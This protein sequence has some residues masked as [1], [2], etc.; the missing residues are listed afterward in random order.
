MKFILCVFIFLTL[1]SNGFSKEI[2]AYFYHN[3]PP[4]AFKKGDPQVGLSEELV[5]LI[6]SK[7]TLK[8][9]K[10]LRPRARLNKEL[11][12]WI[13]LK[14]NLAIPCDSD[15]IVMWVTPKWGWGEK[16]ESRYLW[17]NLFK[18]ED[19]IISNENRKIET[20]NEKE[21]GGMVYAGILGHKAESSIE[22]LL[23]AE[24]I[25][26]EDGT[27]DLAL[28]RRISDGRAGF[29]VLQKSTIDNIFNREE[30]KI[31][32]NKVYI[33]KEPLNSFVLQVMIPLH[34]TDIYQE[35]QKVVN[36]VEFT[37]LLKSYG[38]KK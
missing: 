8:L 3:Q 14:C 32:K 17:I 7:T 38:I 34:R 26:R 35:I 36:S 21:V 23:K 20:I 25:K 33:S 24:K 5:R 28:I 4:F 30:V 2:K 10:S 27:N 31:L 22:V 19:Y 37:N 12:N 6:N 15:W 1:S 13:Q 11:E 9:K 16:A 18:D 29:T